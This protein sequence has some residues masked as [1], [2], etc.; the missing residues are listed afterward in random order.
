MVYVFAVGGTLSTSRVLHNNELCPNTSPSMHPFHHLVE[1]HL[2]LQGLPNIHLEMVLPETLL[3]FRSSLRPPMHTFEGTGFGGERKMAYDV[4]NPGEF[5]LV[6]FKGPGMLKF[7][8]IMVIQTIS[9]GDRNL[10]K[11]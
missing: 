2:I 3:C 1:W 6:T 4:L 9:T 5:A 7:R 10:D 11:L 8:N